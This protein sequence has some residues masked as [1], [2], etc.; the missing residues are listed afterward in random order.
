MAT[1][2]PGVQPFLPQTQVFTPDYKFLQ[3]VL[4]V[5]QDR[6]DT[7]YKEINKLY[8]Q[9]VYAPLSRADSKDKRD[10]YANALTNSL[11]QVA[12]MDLS[13]AQ[14]VNTAKA[15]FSPFY[16]DQDLV[17]DMYATKTFQNSQK[18]IQRYKDANNRDVS[19]NYWLDGEKFVNYRMQD[20]INAT[21]DDARKFNVGDLKYAKNPDIFNRAQEILTEE[22]LEAEDFFMQGDYIYKI[23][24]GP[25][26]TNQ[27]Y[28]YVDENGKVKQGTRNAAMDF[29]VQAL[30]D[31]PKI[32]RG[33]NIKYQNRRREYIDNN[34]SNFAG[35]RNAAGTAFDRDIL[36]NTTQKELKKYAELETELKGDSAALNN[37]LAYKQEY[38]IITGSKEDE[39]YKKLQFEV[40][41]KRKAQ[42][43]LSE[44]IL[45]L[46]GPASN[47]KVLQEKAA[48]AFISDTM[49]KEFYDASV[50][51]SNKNY[52]RDVEV[53]SAA[54]AAKRLAWDKQ[55]F[56]IQ[57]MNKFL[58]EE[59]KKKNQGGD[60][61][62]QL[63]N[64]LNQ[65]DTELNVD[66]VKE[67]Q[68]PLRNVGDG[69]VAID[70]TQREME[71]QAIMTLYNY[72]GFNKYLSGGRVGMINVGTDEEPN[73]LPEAQAGDW[74]R[75]PD[76]ASELNRIF[77]DVT[78][79]LQSTDL[80]DFIGVFA[81][82]DSFK[83]TKD[84][85]NVIQ[86]AINNT[87]LE[88]SGDPGS[89]SGM[90][91]EFYHNLKDQE[92]YYIQT[93]PN[94]Q[95]SNARKS[96]YPSIVTSQVQAQLEEMG[97]PA[98]LIDA[99][100]D[101]V[102]PENS[103]KAGVRVWD[104]LEKIYLANGNPDELKLDGNN[105]VIYKGDKNFYD[106]SRNSG[107]VI[108]N[109]E[110]L[111]NST[112]SSMR[113]NNNSTI[114]GLNQLYPNG[115]NEEFENDWRFN[116]NSNSAFRANALRWNA[117][118]GWSIDESYV[119]QQLIGG[120]GAFY[121]NWVNS[122]NDTWSRTDS[123]ADS[124][125]PY[126]TVMSKIL[127]QD[128]DLGTNMMN[129]FVSRTL[130]TNEAPMT[131][132]ALVNFNAALKALNVAIPQGDGMILQG[133][134]LGQEAGDKTVSDPLAKAFFNDV[135]R[136]ELR[137]GDTSM[138]LTWS[139]LSPTTY[140]NPQTGET[141]NYSA[142]V[143]TL[144]TEFLNK[145][146]DFKPTGTDT[147]LEDSD[148]FK[149]Q[150]LTI[151]VKEEFDKQYNNKHME[152]QMPSAAE[153]LLYANGYYSPQPIAGGGSHHYYRNDQGMITQEIKPVIWDS[154]ANAYVQ[155]PISYRT[156]TIDANQLQNVIML[157]QE[158]L[159][160]NQRTQ[161]DV[162]SGNV[163]IEDKQVSSSG[164]YQAYPGGPF[165]PN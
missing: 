47:Q 16:K 38:G 89:L 61:Q 72:P 14:N 165:L 125:I 147:K 26:L 78:G 59:Q 33:M 92:A 148:M 56:K 138:G 150:T 52:S 96:G 68:N 5:R 100:P 106:F 113:G 101:A 152:N 66:A 28:Q 81:P 39:Q 102:F 130:L 94:S 67:T 123:T 114:K 84:D 161:L 159:I 117:Q 151:L 93:N 7:N 54:V 48:I 143:F 132:D 23:K 107:L 49:Q 53:N 137:V 30:A 134:Y 141:E 65:N 155:D 126:P 20:F 43:K 27:K 41:L 163:S 40:M 149:A 158:S 22:G 12:G 162:K 156:T 17:R 153:R 154:N 87:M 104:Y 83:M 3:N 77:K 35:D 115:P 146:K 139:Q 129:A 95:Y 62:T 46:K 142:Y 57:E 131:E 32:Q 10:Q 140:E 144:P 75:D 63:D 58:L 97:V 88:E 69:L 24:N 85:L 112:L 74:L 70:K 36:E 127:A 19:R 99:G 121:N 91:Q 4:S 86:A 44:R 122:V 160:N 31:D 108:R 34:I 79:K 9:V 55:K 109:Q 50:A 13:L 82:G 6:F 8:G 111:V 71:V 116:K 37:W 15:L 133:N 25:A 42:N 18:E 145:H 124:G 29:V 120:E 157:T 60:S 11:K 110:D 90:T 64:I 128:I 98:Y 136:K 45:T 2:L 105:N 119:R 73:Y 103:N 118:D 80:Q 51:Y 1:Y 135:I 21:A 164:I 76:N